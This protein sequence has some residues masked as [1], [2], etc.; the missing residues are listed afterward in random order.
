MAPINKI[1]NGHCYTWRRKIVYYKYDE[2]TGFTVKNLNNN[3]RYF[4]RCEH[5]SE[6][7]RVYLQFIQAYLQRN[8]HI[9]ITNI[10]CIIYRSAKLFHLI[11]TNFPH[12][13]NKTNKMNATVYNSHKLF[14]WTLTSSI[15]NTI[16]EDND[17]SIYKLSKQIK[18]KK[19]FLKF[20]N[21][22]LT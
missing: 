3:S 18:A 11:K 4:T 10:Q 16:S 7:K 8:N 20:E 12:V 15:R 9:L 6:E 2:L 17:E 13:K 14:W 22:S 21:Y 19:Q 1:C 5:V